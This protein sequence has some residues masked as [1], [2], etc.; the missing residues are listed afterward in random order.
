MGTPLRDSVLPAVFR[1]SIAIA[2]SL[3]SFPTL[4]QVQTADMQETT[5]APGERALVGRLRAPCC[6][7]Q[8]LDVHTGPI[9]DTLRAEIRKRL[10][11]GEAAEHIEA[12]LA[13]RYGERV[14]A[15]P[16]GDPIAGVSLGI[17]AASLAFSGILFLVIRK[18]RRAEKSKAL[19]APVEAP[20]RDAYD[21]R[22][23]DELQA[24][25]ES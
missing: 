6:W 3:A 24:M 1:F 19:P 16:E 21:D 10:W 14:R 20:S 13:A 17:V 11:S 23:D 22:L 8:T 4:A 18:W 5:P 15:V 2:I 9:A 25:S 7:Q 12:D